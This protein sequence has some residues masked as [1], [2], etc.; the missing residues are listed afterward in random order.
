MYQGIE[1]LKCCSGAQPLPMGKVSFYQTASH[2]GQ[3]SGLIRCYLHFVLFCN[4][5]C[6]AVPL[7]KKFK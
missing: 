5:C 3:C 6:S 7:M 4:L 1:R 2:P